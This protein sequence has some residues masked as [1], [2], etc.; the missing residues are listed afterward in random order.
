[1][2]IIIP[3]TG[4]WHSSKAS[5]MISN[6]NLVPNPAKEQVFVT[7]NGIAQASDLKAVIYSIDGAIVK[8]QDLQYGNASINTET[9]KAG[10]YLCAIQNA[11]DTV[12]SQSKLVIIK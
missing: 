2:P 11:D 9:L 6:M 8:V 5:L 7:Y 4:K 12:L 1:M 3:S 10:I